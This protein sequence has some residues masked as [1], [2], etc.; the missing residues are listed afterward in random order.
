[1]KSFKKSGSKGK[2]KAFALVLAIAAMA[3]MLLLTL[4]LSSVITA[5]LRLLNAQK[6]MRA[7]R[8]NAL[9]GMGVAISELQRKLGPDN[10]ISFPATLLDGD[11]TTPEIEGVQAPYLMGALKLNIEN[12]GVNA[13]DLQDERL[14]IFEGL[15]KGGDAEDVSWFVSGEKRLRNPQIEKVEDLSAEVV[16]IAE[17]NVLTDYPGTY[18]DSISSMSKGEKVQVK[19][20]KVR[21]SS[22]AGNSDSAYAW[23]VSD[24]SMKAKINLTRP[25]RYLNETMGDA[26][27]SD[28]PMDSRLPQISNLS[29]VDEFSDMNLNP[30]LDGYDKE[31]ANVFEKLSSLDELA[32]VDSNL[33][34]WAKNNKNDWTATSVGIPVD[35]TQG[36]LKEDMTAYLDGDFGLKKGD[37]IIRGGSGDR[38]Y[39]GPSFGIKNY[40]DNLPR[41]GHIKSW[42][43]IAK[44]LSGF[45]GKAEV[46]P[47]SNN[48]GS[49]E[50]GVYPVVL[51][52]VWNFFPAY[53][54]D[55]TQKGG[56]VKVYLVMYPRIWLWNPNN[57]ALKEHNYII[58]LYMPLGFYMTSDISTRNQTTPVARTAWNK[59]LWDEK[60]GKISDKVSG[61]VYNTYTGSRSSASFIDPN[62]TTD[63]NM[64]VMNFQIKNLGMNPGEVVELNPR[65]DSG[66]LPTYSD[67]PID[68]LGGDDNLLVPGTIGSVGNISDMDI[69]LG[70]GFIVDPGIDLDMAMNADLEAAE[71]DPSSYVYRSQDGKTEYR[72]ASRNS[73]DNP[74]I[75]DTANAMPYLESFW[76]MTGLRVSNRGKLVPPRI[77]YELW[78]GNLKQRILVNDMREWSSQ[79]RPSNTT[80][81]KG[82]RHEDG[83]GIRAFHRTNITMDYEYGYDEKTWTP[84]SD[85]TFRAMVINPL[86]SFHNEIT[87]KNSDWTSG[88][89][90]YAIKGRM[91]NGELYKVKNLDEIKKHWRG[92]AVSR[93]FGFR[94]QDWNES[95]AT[96]FTSHNLRGTF[97]VSPLNTTNAVIRRPESRNGDRKNYGVGLK[98]TR[99]IDAGKNDLLLGGGNSD[100]NGYYS[101]ANGVLP[102]YSMLSSDNLISAYGSN[103]PDGYA[104]RYGTT[105]FMSGENRIKGYGY[106]YHAS[107]PFDYPRKEEDLMSLG[108]LSHA[109]LSPMPWQPSWAF[110][111]S[112]PSPYMKRDEIYED[113]YAGL[114]QAN[115]LIDI[116]YMLNASMWDRFYMSSLYRDKV[117]GQLKAGMRLPNTR[118]FIKKLPTKTSELYGSDDAFEKSAAYIGI[119]GVFN[120]NSTSYEAWRAFL[121][122]MLGTKKKTL[123]NETIN[124]DTKT[125]RDPEKFKMPNP[126]GMNPIAKPADTDKY[127]YYHYMDTMVGRTISEAEIDEL[128]REIVAEVKRRAPFFG[129]SDFVNRRILKYESGASD[130]DVNKK[131]QGLMGTISAAIKRASMDID[132]SRPSYFFNSKTLEYDKSNMSNMN[133]GSFAAYIGRASI[134]AHDGDWG[135]INGNG[136]VKDLGEAVRSS[137]QDS[138][139]VKHEFY[140]QALRTPWIEG[141]KYWAT[142]LE[143][144]PG[145]LN[146]RDIL[147]MIGP[148]ISV[149]GD[150]FTVRAYGESKNPMTGATSKAYCEAVVQRSSDPVNPADDIVAPESPFGRRF[151]VVS[152]RWLTPAEL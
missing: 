51:K 149:R 21:F 15:R 102:R 123:T 146:Q 93:A 92:A 87:F 50:H 67:K 74:D 43:E 91:D 62:T 103:K 111:D 11:P 4:T 75:N 97:T 38:N 80:N 147:T 20:G 126:G 94:M 53:E 46:K 27:S 60:E 138:D 118:Y 108:A 141:G 127:E 44:G 133:E 83:Y 114:N 28:A 90:V 41:F 59:H 30:F 151:N 19:A 121:G 86:D 139:D 12:T 54:G 37:V 13:K 101:F 40:T 35:V 1:M 6:E 82:Y 8:S 100:R 115:E 105:L 144:M 33:A 23:W 142:K 150:T 9:L 145:M 122:G 17:F 89:F 130:E 76:Y 125:S 124:S 63:A 136:G 106:D 22:N 113:P 140:E 55:I 25:E 7:A 56:R 99:I 135:S 112:F 98:Y 95:W 5:K 71:Y 81:G 131:Y 42:S 58:S 72:P 18:G 2:R 16:N 70:K 137:K 26:K 31:S 65:S 128:A 84:S 148:F 36:R 96:P 110:G 117:S 57:V 116:S 61:V 34:E 66:K 47:W 134:T 88:K 39:K 77:G 49:P 143:G 109:N 52:A 45:S 107:A 129:I 29:F 119:D 104:E 85:T 14:R 120:V 78:D 3:F 69:N 10:A 68:S 132:G 48:P 24:E 73:D 152:F 32:I 79:D 64:P